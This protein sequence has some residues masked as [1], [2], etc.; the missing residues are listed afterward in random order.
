MDLLDKRKISFASIAKRSTFYRLS[1]PSVVTVLTDYAIP[2][3]ERGHISVKH[4]TLN[5]AEIS[6]TSCL[7]VQRSPTDCGASLCVI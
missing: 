4:C 3:P 6:A 7:L 2:A 1:I 5:Q